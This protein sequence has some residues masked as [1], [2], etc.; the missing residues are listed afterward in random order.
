MKQYALIDKNSGFLWATVDAK[1]PIDA[2]F[3][4]DQS[5]SPG[6]QYRY[7]ETYS[8]GNWTYAAHE[9]PRGKYAAADGQNQDVIDEI[10]ALPVAEYVGRQ[11]L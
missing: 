10:S 2:C 8:G 9:V 3:E 11:E 6:D 4:A 5:I 1:S 7:F